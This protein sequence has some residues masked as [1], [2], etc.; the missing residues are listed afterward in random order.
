MSR[1]NRVL[2]LGGTAVLAALP[3]A[4]TVQPASAAPCYGDCKPG[5][6]RLNGGRPTAVTTFPGSGERG[7]VQA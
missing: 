5:V 4:S 7:I 1:K 6:V 2:L 3:F